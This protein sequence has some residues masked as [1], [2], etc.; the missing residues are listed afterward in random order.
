M[1][2]LLLRAGADDDG[3]VRDGAGR[4]GGGVRRR[5]SPAADYRLYGPALDHSS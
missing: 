2:V 1:R 3:A 4:A 5:L